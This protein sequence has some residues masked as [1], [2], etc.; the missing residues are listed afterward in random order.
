MAAQPRRIDVPVEMP[1]GVS[2]E[3]V[4]G[5][6]SADL[7]SQVK[8][9]GRQQVRLNGGVS[10]FAGSFYECQRKR[11]Q[12]ESRELKMLPNPQQR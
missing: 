2:R 3:G 1:E 8:E 11:A 12:C 10:G 4:F 9:R 5:Q 6:E 7:N